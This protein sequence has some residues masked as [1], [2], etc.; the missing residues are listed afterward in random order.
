VVFR[1]GGL[2]LHAAL[3]LFRILSEYSVI[4]ME[5]NGAA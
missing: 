1:E 2:L 3:F 4:A 5:V